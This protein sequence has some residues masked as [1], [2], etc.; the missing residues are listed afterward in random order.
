MCEN[1]SCVK[2]E[3]GYSNLTEAMYPNTSGKVLIPRSSVV[4][5]R[6]HNGVTT[7]SLQLIP[8]LSQEH[9]YLIVSDVTAL[10]PIMPSTCSEV[11]I[12]INHPVGFSLHQTRAVLSIIIRNRGKVKLWL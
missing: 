1:S 8:D 2:S 10:K 5:R 9:L 4:L 11:I 7:A 3:R 6:E 12:R